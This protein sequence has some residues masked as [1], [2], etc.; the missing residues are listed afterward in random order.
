M[1]AP[2]EPQGISGVGAVDVAGREQVDQRIAT[3]RQGDCVIGD[4]WFLFRTNMGN[5]LTAAGKAAV[6][7][8][9]ENAET[10]VRG[11]AV[12]TQTCDL[13]RHCGDRPF[14]EVSPLVEVNDQVLREIER[15]RRPNYGFIPGV[16][17]RRLV[18]DL[19]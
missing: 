7:E 11:F 1:H 3:W 19:D 10:S 6:V 17:D 4:D 9:V 15:G 16:A 12:L 13:V 2:L 18:A 14:A 8:G 5:P